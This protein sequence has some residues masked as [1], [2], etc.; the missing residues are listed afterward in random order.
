VEQVDFQ[1]PKCRALFKAPASLEGE[2]FDCPKCK[3]EIDRWPAPISRPAGSVVPTGRPGG[4]ER[5]PMWFY[6]LG[7]KRR[8]PATEAQLKALVES[9]TLRPTDLVWR[10]GMPGWVAA[11]WLPGLFPPPASHSPAPH[12]PAGHPPAPLPPAYPPAHYPP[13]PVPVPMPPQPPATATQ[14]E[15]RETKECP[16]CCE[17]ISVRAKKCPVCG[18]TIDV[19]MRE[20]EEARREAEEAR[21]EAD[22]ARREARRRPR[23]EYHYH[24]RRPTCPHALH[25]ILTIFTVGLWLPIWIIHAIV[26]ECS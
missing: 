15:Y 9:G 1:C 4:P 14:V 5:E 8:G 12:T 23:R 7:D 13:A 10:E 3:A 11:S 22:E 2:A 17:T 25:L 16:F 26:V 20:A 18:Q 19:A 21:R 24:D 6:M